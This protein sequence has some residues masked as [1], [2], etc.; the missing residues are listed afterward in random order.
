[1]KLAFVYVAERLREP[2]TAASI[3]AMLIGLGVHVDAGLV[4]YVMFAV[5]GVA[6][7]AG[8]FLPESK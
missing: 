8:F 3:S 6:G 7:A 2:S 5:A 4:Q 1:M